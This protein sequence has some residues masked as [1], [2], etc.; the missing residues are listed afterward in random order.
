MAVCEVTA[1]VATSAATWMQQQSQLS[2]AWEAASGAACVSHGTF[3]EEGYVPALTLPLPEG[4][5]GED[6]TLPGDIV[7]GLAGPHTGWRSTGTEGIGPR[8]AGPGEPGQ[9]IG[10]SGAGARKGAGPE[11]GAE[12]GPGT[13]L[14]CL[15]GWPTGPTLGD[16]AGLP[17]EGIGPVATMTGAGV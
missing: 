12:T 9:G 3:A 13:G 15:P 17:G 14:V 2:E 11:T 10:P 7:P 6:Q 5:D 4:L 8:G 16:G 1:T